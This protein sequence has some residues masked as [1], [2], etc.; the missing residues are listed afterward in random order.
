ME[1]IHSLLAGAQAWLQ[2][3]GVGTVGIQ[4]VRALLVAIAFHAGV[5]AIER[6][7]GTRGDDYRSREY[8][9]DMT[10]WFWYRTGLN[11][12]LI[13]ALL[14]PPLD[15]PIPWLDLG[16][17]KDFSLPTQ[18]LVFFLCSD[19]YA[20]W[21]HRAYHRFEFLWAFHTMH[22]VPE[23][24]T[25]ASSARF[26][27]VE[28][29]ITYIGFYLMVRIAGVNPL[30]WFPIMLFMEIMLNAQ[31]TRIPWKLGPLYRV[32]VTP[33]FHRLHHSV[34]PRHFDR[35]FG[36]MLSI[37]DHLFGTALPRDEAPPRALGIAGVRH[38]SLWS[39]L[40]DPFRLAWSQARRKRDTAPV[41]TP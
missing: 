22:H 10:Y 37:W 25:F 13:V 4:F 20:Y 1:D 5:Y 2:G 7:T 41:R 40:A 36:A 17:L 16:L 35:N 3:L 8:R 33:S 29:A 27:P 15:R 9:Y 34:E 19:L 26:H 21:S 39:T 18:A 38:E 28:I 12:F 6:L 23:R 30:V 14:F 11:Y 32:F 24:I 31:H